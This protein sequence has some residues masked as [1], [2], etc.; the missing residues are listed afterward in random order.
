MTARENAELA[1]N[2]NNAVEVLTAQTGAL[3]KELGRFTI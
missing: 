3:K 2:L 1:S